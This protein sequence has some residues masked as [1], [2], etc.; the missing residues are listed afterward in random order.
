MIISLAEFEKFRDLVKKDSVLMKDVAVISYV[1]GYSSQALIMAMRNND[2][3]NYFSGIKK[4]VGSD[5]Y[6][7]LKAECVANT[8]D[9]AESVILCGEY[10]ARRHRAEYEKVKDKDELVDDGNTRHSL[11][12]ESSDHDVVEQVD[13]I[14][15]SVLN[16]YWYCNG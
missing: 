3:D 9:V 11:R 4:I 13:E 16:D 8:L 12:S 2:L 1:M 10:S 7:K 15:Q 6:K 5:E 14:R